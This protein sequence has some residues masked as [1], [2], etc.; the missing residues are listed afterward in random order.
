MYRILCCLFLLGLSA[1]SPALNWRHV[2]LPALALDA[3]LPCK[4]EHLE[5]QIEL[6]GYPAQAHL[7]GCSAQGA[8]FAV[9]CAVLDDPAQAGLALTH[10]RA[11]V[12]AALQ[13]PAGPQPGAP[14]DQPFVPAKAL[15]IP[16]SVRT[17][18][19]GQQPGG[20]KVAL[21]A[22]WF[23]R[24]QGPIVRACHAVVYA[25]QLQPLD[26]DAFFAGL[27]LQ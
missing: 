23:A 20:G 8:T 2:T 10:W 26:A 18:A 22:V 7:A 21:Q 11:A 25:T 3:S 27:V 19:Q 15:A 14:Q 16:Q 9:S 1:C 4:P 5:R 13:A 6:A 17:T 12:L 24:V